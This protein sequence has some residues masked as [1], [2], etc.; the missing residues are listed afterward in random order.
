M[1]SFLFALLCFCIWKQCLSHS[2]NLFDILSFHININLISVDLFS[3]H[4][5]DVNEWVCVCMSVYLR[6]YRSLCLS[7]CD[8]LP[9]AE[10]HRTS[11]V[12]QFGLSF[13]YLLQQSSSVCLLHKIHQTLFHY[14]IFCHVEMFVCLCFVCIF[15][16]LF[17][18][19]VFLSRI[20]FNI[21]SPA[22][23]TTFVS[24]TCCNDYVRTRARIENA[25]YFSFLPDHVIWTWHAG[26]SNNLHV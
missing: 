17:H 12:R 1:T 20:L 11:T 5:L 26:I 25:H 15:N 23:F 13:Y 4:L 21:N 18:E 2:Y 10:S 8:L 9:S 3:S 24:A 6:L 7:V 22:P 14:I 16:L 19:N